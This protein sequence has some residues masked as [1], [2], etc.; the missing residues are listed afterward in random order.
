M[1]C[2]VV[3]CTRCHSLCYISLLHLFAT[4][5]YN[6]TVASIRP[7]IGQSISPG[8]CMAIHAPLQEIKNVCIKKWQKSFKNFTMCRS[9]RQPSQASSSCN[10]IFTSSFAIAFQRN[11]YGHRKDEDQENEIKIAHQHTRAAKRSG[12]WCAWLEKQAKKQVASWLD[13]KLKIVRTRSSTFWAFI[14]RVDC[15]P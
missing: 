10:F 12:L 2:V 3:R 6:G 15:T 11:F 9:S 4:S 1:M 5:L 8:I 14:I 13:A 7:S